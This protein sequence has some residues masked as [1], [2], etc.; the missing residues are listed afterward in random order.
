MKL[1]ILLISEDAD[2]IPR[3]WQSNSNSGLH[4]KAHGSVAHM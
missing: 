4:E 1:E 3:T 2:L